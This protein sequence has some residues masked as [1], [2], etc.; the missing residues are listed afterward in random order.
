MSILEDD[1]HR[2]AHRPP[3]PEP[4]LRER[5]STTT[6]NTNEQNTKKRLAHSPLLAF[7][8][9]ITKSD[10]QTWKTP[11]SLRYAGEPGM[12]LPEWSNLRNAPQPC[13]LVIHSAARAPWHSTPHD[14][15]QQKSLTVGNHLVTLM[16]TIWF[17]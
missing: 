10:N 3:K 1:H 16:E 9:S 12:F 6:K 2:A 5:P 14:P 13:Y 8:S 17:P 11:L 7:P 4:H 15:S